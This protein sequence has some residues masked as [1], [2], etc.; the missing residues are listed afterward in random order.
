[1]HAHA[2]YG[3]WTDIDIEEKEIKNVMTHDNKTTLKC[4]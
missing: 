1:M 3:M 2:F 4:H